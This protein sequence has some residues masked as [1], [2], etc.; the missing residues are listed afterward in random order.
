MR[1]EIGVCIAAGWI[2]WANGPHRCGTYSDEAIARRD[3]HYIL[4]AGEKYIAD[5]GCQSRFAVVPDDMVTEQEQWY[6]QMCR[7]RHETINRLFKTFDSIANTF[8]RGVD[9]H[10]LFAH[11][12]INIVQV[13]IMHKELQP[14][15]VFPFEWEPTTWPNNL[16]GRQR[17]QGQGE[18]EE[19]YY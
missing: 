3:L 18:D 8:Q 12:I 2:V 7:T 16:H 5:G 13:G 1:Y 11:S 17:A 15:S 10:A 6:A 19:D 4:D 9:K 14:F